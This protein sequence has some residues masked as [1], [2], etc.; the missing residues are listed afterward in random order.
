MIEG[1]RRKGKLVDV[2]R[3]TF[4]KNELDKITA[5]PEMYQLDISMYNVCILIINNYVDIR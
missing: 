4:I 5:P 2:D 1:K 3:N